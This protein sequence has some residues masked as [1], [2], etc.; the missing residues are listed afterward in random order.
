MNFSAA[1]SSF[2]DRLS[3]IKPASASTRYSQ[4]IG[5]VRAEKCMRPLRAYFCLMNARWWFIP[6][7]WVLS[8]IRHCPVY[9]FPLLV[10]YLLQM[11]VERPEQVAAE[12]GWVMAVTCALSALNVVCAVIQEMLQSRDRRGLTAGLREA[13]MR[14]LHRVSFGSHDK[15]E[16]GALQNKF[17]M[18]INQLEWLQ[19]YLIDFLTRLTAIIVCLVVVLTRTPQLAP[20]LLLT[21][22]ANFV[23]GH[24]LW[25]YVGRYHDDLRRAESDFLVSLNEGL[26]GIRLAR[27]HASEDHSTQRLGS[28][29]RNVAERGV[30]LDFVCCLF[31]TTSWATGSLL[32]M[33]VVGIGAWFCVRGMAQISDLYLFFQYYLIISG[34]MAAVIGGMPGMAA[35]RNALKSLCELYDDNKLE[36]GGGQQVGAVRGDVELRDV[37]FTYPGS[38]RPS[39]TEVSLSIPSGTSLALVGPSGAGKST[40]GSLMLGFY[41]PQH[42]SV[43][44]DGRDIGTLDLRD[45]RRHV[46]VVTQ[47]IVLFQDTIIGNIAWGDPHPDFERARYAAWL[48]NAE[49]FIVRLPHGYH[50][51]LGERGTGLS[52]GQRQRLSIARA[53][54]RDPKLL[55][56]DEATSALDPDS[57][58]LVQQALETLM[59]GRSTL[60]IAHRISTVR[61]ATKICVLDEGRVVEQG[62]FEELLAAGGVFARL[63]SAALYPVPGDDS[64]GPAQLY[65]AREKAAWAK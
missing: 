21:V 18:D 37:T 3:R 28:A 47:E 44:I 60:I 65:G 49:E 51:M 48:A 31:G 50:T 42:G 56:L 40:I 17:T 46:S 53:L 22:L 54:Y 7:L 52:G 62:N 14:R 25:K 8:N 57:E 10:A 59:R 27:A 5:Q 26:S 58:R 4:K 55:I 1:G 64:G 20:V 16:A 24:I 34:A 29:A 2:L 63:A 36:R 32:H 30:R 9:V 45:L 23:L 11:L 12:I 39:L 38:N 33:L 41:E 35:S 61:N 13:V 19:G 15:M 43:T 6:V